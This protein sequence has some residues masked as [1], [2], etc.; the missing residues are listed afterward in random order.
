MF[1]SAPSFLD[2][3][4]YA[5]YNHLGYGYGACGALNPLAQPWGGFPVATHSIVSHSVT[6]QS[7][8][9]Y[10]HGACGLF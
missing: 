7:F 3:G 6:T 1:F 9:S 5:P 8:T 2:A 10:P 4:L